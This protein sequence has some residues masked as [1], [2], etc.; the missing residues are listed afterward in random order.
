MEGKPACTKGEQPTQAVGPCTHMAQ[1][2]RERRKGTRNRQEQNRCSEASGRGQGP[3]LLCRRDDRPGEMATGLVSVYCCLQYE[4]QQLGLSRL[5]CT[6]CDPSAGTGRVRKYRHAMLPVFS[7]GAHAS[8]TCAREAGS[9][10]ACE[11]AAQKAEVRARS[12][13]EGSKLAPEG[14]AHRRM[15]LWCSVTEFT[16]PQGR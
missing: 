13:K 14:K 8:Q 12:A 7:S 15:Q 5:G 11:G 1:W 16:I 4:H 2:R 3:C 10:A 9:Q 6:L